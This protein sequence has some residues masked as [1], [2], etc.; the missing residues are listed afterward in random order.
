[1]KRI[2]VFLTICAGLIILVACTSSGSG[3]TGKVWALNELNGARLVA[4][5]GISAQFTSDGKVTGSAGCNQYSGTYTVSG[6]SIKFPSPLAMTMMMCEQSLMDQESAY[7]KSLGDAN[8]FEVKGD[9]L[10]LIDANKT[11]LAVYKAQSQDLSGTSWESTGYNNGKQAVT[12]PLQGTTLTADFGKDGT[13]SGN[14]GCNTFSGGY[15]VNGN[16]ITI[17]PLASTMMACSDPAGV[18][19]QEAQYLAALQSAATYQIEGNVL[20]L[21]TKDDA[22]AAMFNKK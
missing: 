7:L 9:Q 1:M 5:S 18:M 22:L 8:R 10:T 2:L 20:Q 12:G 11:N 21:R 15:K 3:L 4:G 16:Q 13:L 19:D 6:S 17:G 14:S